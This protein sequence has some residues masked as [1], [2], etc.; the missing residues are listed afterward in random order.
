MRIAV[1]GSPQ[2]WYFRDLQRAADGQ[3]LLVSLP[4]SSVSARLDKGRQS[5][6]AGNQR[7]DSFDAVLVRTMPPGSLE[8]VVFRMDLLAQL[9]RQGVPVI[10]PPR[11]IEIAVD[12]YLS[13]S[14]L[15]N[16]GLAVPATI[17]CQSIEAAMQA[18]EELGGD[19]VLTPIFG[20]EGRGI[21]RLEDA[22]VALR[23]FKALTGLGA[24]IYLQQFI[25]Q[26][27]FDTRVLLLGDQAFAIRRH[28]ADDWRSNLSRGA[29]AEPIPVDPDSLLLAQQAAAATGALIAGVDL[30]Q[31][32]DGTPL[33]LEVN[34]VPGWR[35]LAAAHQVDV[36]DLLL[37]WIDR[38]LHDKAESPLTVVD[39][40]GAA[41]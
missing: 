8:Q 16:A 35:G 18:F 20:G 10:N 3:H 32:A 2:S 12:K 13:L 19:V 24:V 39:A 5:I 38:W 21:S 9:E 27:G 33:I 17:V 14:C 15:Q 4:F 1:L 6:W 26:P 25:P 36:A 23:A 40:S 37:D 30:I 11:A 29:T 31:A 22:D 7:L 34:G 28:V 41:P